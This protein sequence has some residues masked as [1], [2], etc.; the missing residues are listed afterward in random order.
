MRATMAMQT[1]QMVM[2][3]RPQLRTSK[4]GDQPGGLGGNVVV[5]FRVSANPNHVLMKSAKNGHCA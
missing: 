5:Y 1:D 3:I 4:V 2:I